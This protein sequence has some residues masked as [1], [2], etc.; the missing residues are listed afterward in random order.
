MAKK[1]ICGILVTIIVWIAFVWCK[2]I[3]FKKEYS[4]QEI[5]TTFNDL[6]LNPP[7]YDSIHLGENE[8][9]YLTNKAN[10]QSVDSKPFLFLLHDSGKN[11]A[12]FLRYFKDQNINQNYHLI[13]IDRIG[14]GKTIANE[15]MSYHN[16]VSIFQKSIQ[17]ILSKEELQDQK[18]NFISSGSSSM[19]GILAYDSYANKNTKTFIFYPKIDP[20]FIASKLLSELFVSFKIL[21]PEGFIKKQKDLLFW[22]FVRN[23]DQ[24]TWLNKAKIKEEKIGKENKDY[25]GVYFMVTNKSFEHKVNEITSS[26]SFVIEA[27]K[28]RSIYRKPDFVKNIIEK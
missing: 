16:K 8:I 20:R 15:D 3:F 2:Y 14:F 12:F 22:D 21:F 6:G 25:K 18:L 9:Y 17:H 26:K 19:A 24:V 23:E 28:R 7:I 10:K 11:A 13:A 27:V 5:N 4:Q 1:I